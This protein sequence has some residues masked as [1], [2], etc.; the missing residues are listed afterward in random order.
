MRRPA[1]AHGMARI[2]ELQKEN[3]DALAQI[4][5]LQKENAALEAML[6]EAKAL[7][8]Q[9]HLPSRRLPPDYHGPLHGPPSA[10]GTR[11]RRRKG[12][13]PTSRSY[14]PLTRSSKGKDCN[15]IF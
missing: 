3:A 7:K 5:E 2:A 15:V 8:A 6:K 12:R 11:R 13:Q 9:H 1:A 4:A 10:A 14:H